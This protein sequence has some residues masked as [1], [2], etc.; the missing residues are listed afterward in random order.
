MMNNFFFR[1]IHLQEV[2]ASVDD[3]DESGL[4]FF[5]F[6]F[7]LVIFFPFLLLLLEL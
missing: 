4:F 2:D 3:G 1:K 7:I 5:W 6:D